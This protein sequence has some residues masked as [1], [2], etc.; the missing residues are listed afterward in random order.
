MIAVGMPGPHSEGDEDTLDR[1]QDGNGDD[2]IAT[3]AIC[4]IARNLHQGGPSA[5]RDLRK[6]TAALEDMCEAFMSKDS[7]GFDDAAHAA[8]EALNDLME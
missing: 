1:E 6:F 7:H 3:E 4:S 2:D 5:V 8:R